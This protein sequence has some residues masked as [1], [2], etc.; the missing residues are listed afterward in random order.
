M[1]KSYEKNKRLVKNYQKI[2]SLK[3]IQAMDYFKK[4]KEKIENNKYDI[5]LVSDDASGF[6]KH[7]SENSL[8]KD[9]AKKHAI[10]FSKSLI[11]N[12]SLFGKDIK[13]ILITL[14][15]RILQK[16]LPA[17]EFNYLLNNSIHETDHFHIKL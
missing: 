13:I 15:S 9:Y 6:S 7:F 17:N 2:G 5:C 1:K 8:E 11:K 3:L 14:E 4:S 10:Q 12:L 16:Q